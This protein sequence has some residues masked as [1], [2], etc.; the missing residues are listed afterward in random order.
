V[1]RNQPAKVNDVAGAIEVQNFFA[2]MDWMQSSGD[3]LS[4][5]THL[6]LSPLPNVPAK[7]AMFLIATGDRTVPNPQESSLIRAAGM[8]STTSLFR[9]DLA[10]AVAKTF[11]QP[12]PDDPHAFLVNLT[13]F[14]SS[15]VA[16]AAQQI[17][18]GYLS[19]N[20][21]TIPQDAVNAQIRALLRV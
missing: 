13:S 7:K 12:L 6:A 1:L 15:L 16:N 2:T 3:P 14:A 18:S 11:G 10:A 20:G 21:A 9:N 19:S 17:V 8:L 4:Y 5:A